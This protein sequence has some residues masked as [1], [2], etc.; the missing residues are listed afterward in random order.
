MVGI[1]Q[2]ESVS[3]VDPFVKKMGDQM[4]YVVALDATGSITGGLMKEFQVSGIPAAFI[5]NYQNGTVQWNG[6][7]MDPEFE[8][9]IERAA[10][11]MFAISAAG[12]VESNRS[13]FRDD[14]K[15]MGN[16]RDVF[17]AK[18]V[19][20][21]KQILQ[22]CGISAIGCVEKRDI[23]NKIASELNIS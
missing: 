8:E 22:D 18:S 10:R 16:W 21:L 1:S 19:K 12:K 6:H 7:P 14:L 20:E 23:V 11:Q 15:Q 9:Q 4:D 17:E 3:T 13:K 2:G 5:V